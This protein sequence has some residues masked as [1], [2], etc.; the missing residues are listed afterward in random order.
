MLPSPIRDIREEI[1]MK[2]RMLS[3]ALS[4][5]LL[6]GGVAAVV[7]TAS[8]ATSGVAAATMVEYALHSNVV[9]TAR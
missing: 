7:V 2:K 1:T 5:S 3:L 9:N 4:A 8:S 6:S